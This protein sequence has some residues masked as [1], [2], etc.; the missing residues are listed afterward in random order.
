MTERNDKKST[1]KRKKTVI[2][3]PPALI[4]YP[5]A[6]IM[7]LI[8][9]IKYHV[10]VD[11]RALKGVRGP[12][13]VLAPH[14]SGKDHVL[15]GLALFPNRPTYVL[16]EHF[17][18]KKFLR[19]ILR[20]IHA[21]PKKMFCPDTRSVLNM[22]RAVREGNVLV[23]FPEGRLTWYG[24]SLG[25]TD[26]TAELVLRMG[27]DV[28]TVVSDGAGMTFPKWAKYKRRGKIHIRTEKL[29]DGDKVK[30]MSPD[31]ING[32]LT[33]HLRHDAETAMPGV[34]F[35]TK[36]T[37]AGL[38]GILWR[39]PICGSTDCLECSDGNIVCGECRLERT[40]DEYGKLKPIKIRYGGNTLEGQALIGTVIDSVADWYEYCAATVDTSAPI[41]RRCEVGKT[42]KDGYMHRNVGEGGMRLDRDSFSFTGT[43]NG[44]DTSFS[45]TTEKLA[46]FP[47][48]VGDHI[49]VYVDGTLWYLTPLPDPRESVKFV[50][51]LDRVTAERKAAEKHSVL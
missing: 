26:G 20:M 6:V 11:R 7:S 40:L 3:K 25:I 13:V 22:L 8:Y 47:I 2:G 39:C 18:S 43:V 5:A 50:A 9:R 44:Y 42:D 35:R 15:T 41:V 37:T 27:V 48:T 33:E 24:R 30:T 32:F 4:Y 45:I 17:M 36:D 21:I 10:T 49:D 46:A 28:Y 14:V 16:S 1:D 38:D 12:A 31:E 34:K 19:P 29:L 23:L 51:F